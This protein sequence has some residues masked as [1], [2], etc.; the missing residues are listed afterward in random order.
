MNAGIGTDIDDIVG[1]AHGILVVLDDDQ[2]IAQIPQ[3]FERGKQFFVV[4]LMKPDGGL[5][6]NIQNA[7]QPRADLGR[8]ADALRLPA[9]KRARAARERQIAQADVRQEGKPR[10]DFL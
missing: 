3:M 10:P 7:G 2:G 1:G 6:Q 9:R 5:V 8:Q 4:P